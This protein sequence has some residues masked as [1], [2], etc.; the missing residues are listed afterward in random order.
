MMVAELVSFQNLLRR[1]PQNG[2]SSSTPVHDGG[3]LYATWWSSE[4]WVRGWSRGSVVFFSLASSVASIWILGELVGYFTGA[5]KGNVWLSFGSICVNVALFV[6]IMMFLAGGA[7]ESG[8][9]G[10]DPNP[11]FF[12]RWYGQYFQN[13]MVRFLGSSNGAMN[14]ANKDDLAWNGRLV[15]LQR[16][17]AN[18]AKDTRKDCHDMLRGVENSVLK[19]ETMIR[20]E[21]SGLEKSMVEMLAEQREMKEQFRALLQKRGAV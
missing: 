20:S 14:G 7:G 21:V 18:L 2:P 11:I 5:L 16:E 8:K 6:G 1:C 4:S 10:D 13:A 19:G 17:M 15:Y 12:F 3:P 9:D